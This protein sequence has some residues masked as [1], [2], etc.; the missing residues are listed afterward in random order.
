MKNCEHVWL[1]SVAG[2]SCLVCEKCGAIKAR[3]S[4][5]LP[6]VTVKIRV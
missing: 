4:N 5:G 2:L 6:S 3:V 1:K